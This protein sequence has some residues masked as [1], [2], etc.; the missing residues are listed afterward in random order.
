[1]SDDYLWDKKGEPDPEIERLEG[2]LGSLRH[3]AAWRDPADSAASA[4]AATAPLATAQTASLHREAAAGAQ[5]A[6]VSAS[7]LAIRKGALRRRQAWMA[8]GALAL[9]AGIALAIGILRYGGSEGGAPRAGG[10]APHGQ[11]VNLGAVG[12]IPPELP[13]SLPACSPTAEGFAW[14]ATS[15]VSCGGATASAGNLPAGT[16]MET[17][18]GAT[19]SLQI[20]NIGAV[21]LLGGSKLRVVATGPKEHRLELVRGSLHAK[22]EAPPRLFVI[23][24]RAATAVDLGCEYDMSIDDRGRSHLRVAVG[25]VSLEGKGRAAYVPAGTA[26]T[27]DPE[28]GPGVVLAFDATRALTTAAERVEGGETGALDELLA[29]AGEGDSFTLWNL[30]QGTTQEIRERVLKR[31]EALKMRPAKVKRE[32]IVAGHQEALLALR[33]SLEDAWFEPPAGKG[34]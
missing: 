7:P 29:S 13:T 21:Q 4:Q 25:A 9:A 22:V 17:G 5:A 10:G 34:R 31:M 24:T 23:D 1:M 28:R 18:E 12:A 14:Q 32:S 30:L 27:A 8:A 6:E 3:E 19:V 33:A 20:A 26:I 16:W 15:P 2:A 11:S